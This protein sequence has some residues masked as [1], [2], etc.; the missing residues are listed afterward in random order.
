MAQARLALEAHFAGVELLQVELRPSTKL[1]GE[2]N[3]WLDEV[4]QVDRLE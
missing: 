3:I 4:E 2:T 1:T